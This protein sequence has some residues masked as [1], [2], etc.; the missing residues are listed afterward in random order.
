MEPLKKRGSAVLMRRA[1]V[2]GLGAWASAGAGNPQRAPPRG[3]LPAE[4]LV[5]PSFWG[6]GL[7]NRVNVFQGSWKL[8]LVSQVLPRETKRTPR[9]EGFLHFG[10]S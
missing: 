7:F 2:V 1:L 5:Y 4:Q 10:G 9:P 3:V 6:G 8:G